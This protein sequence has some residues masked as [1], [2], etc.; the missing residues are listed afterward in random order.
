MSEGGVDLSGGTKFLRVPCVRLSA[1][2]DDLEIPDLCACCGVETES[3]HTVPYCRKC[4]RH[5]LV[6][7]LII[8]CAGAASLGVGLYANTVAATIVATLNHKTH[9]AVVFGAALAIPLVAYLLLELLRPRKIHAHWGSSVD[10]GE[11]DTVFLDASMGARVGELN[12]ITPKR[13]H[14]FRMGAFNSILLLFLLPGIPAGFAYLGYDEMH[15]TLYVDNGLDK[16][17]TLR[18][19][20]RD[21]LTLDGQGAKRLSLRRLESQ[22]EAVDENGSIDRISLGPV[23]PTKAPDEIH[24][25]GEQGVFVWNVDQRNCYVQTTIHYDFSGGT[26]KENVIANFKVIA[27]DAEYIFEL[28]PEVITVERYDD[29]EVVQRELQRIPCDE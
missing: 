5:Q 29:R 8:V 27:T 17:I 18:L 26:F 25:D 11:E 7:K 13:I 16:P 6:Y 15:L 1:N 28:A 4:R 24:F 21:L 19:D 20:G 23:A 10:R 2:L 9:T 14:R 12:R 22:L 3:E